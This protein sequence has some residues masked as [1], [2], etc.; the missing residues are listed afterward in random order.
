MATKIKGKLLVNGNGN[1]ESQPYPILASN[2]SLS[3][4]GGIDEK[5]GIVIDT[6]HPLCGQSVD[7]TILCLPSG[8]GS[9]TASQVLLELILNG[10]APKALI[11]RDRDGLVSVGAL[12]AQSIFPEVKILDVIQVDRFD[13]LLDSRYGQILA[14]GSVVCGMELDDVQEMM[15]EMSTA[16]DVR[17]EPIVSLTEEEQYMLENAKNDAEKR[18]VECIIQYAR[19]NSDEPTYVDVEKAHIDGCTYIGPGG[20]KFVQRLV[21][22][23]GM[24]RIPTTLNSVS[25]DLRNWDRLGIIPT[26]SQQASI[27]L[28]EA[29]LALGC[30]EESFTCAPY[31]LDSPPELGQQIVWGESNAVVFANSVL[32]ART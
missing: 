31:L 13:V 24:V 12:I 30:S 11:L 26:E 10:K 29:Y 23:G 1:G 19:I 14:D 27:E 21:A 15:K 8:R 3:F 25:T 6:T 2:V 4:W 16:V 22:D 20:L 7:G 18:A 17:S 9:C 28:A 5:T 32:G